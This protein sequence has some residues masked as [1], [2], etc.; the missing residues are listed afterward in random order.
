MSNDKDDGALAIILAFFAGGLVGSVLGLLLAPFSGRETRERILDTTLETKDRT[1]G[2]ATQ[3]REL[4]AQSFE[5]GTQA[6]QQR[7]EEVAIELDDSVE[8][9][10]PEK[11]ETLESTPQVQDALIEEPTA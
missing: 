4:A 10:E 9:S 1:V 2:V 3:V 7:K 8:T 11:M 6:F 5:A